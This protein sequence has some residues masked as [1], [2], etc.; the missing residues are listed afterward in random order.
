MAEKDFNPKQ[1]P[2]PKDFGLPYVE[3]KPLSSVRSNSKETDQ[4]PSFES[5]K[6]S[7]F[8]DKDKKRETKTNRPADASPSRA[9]SGKKKVKT[10]VWLV[11]IAIIVAVTVIVIQLNSNQE[12]I[13][14]QENLDVNSLHTTTISNYFE[15]SFK[16]A[17]SNLD[18]LADQ[19]SSVI[20]D[21][22]LTS[23]STNSG[24]S[25]ATNPKVKRVEQKEGNTRYYI[26]IGSFASE[27][28]T[29]RYIQN[30]GDKFSEYY[31]V[32]PFKKNQ[33]YR[34]AIGSYGTLKEASAKLKEMKAQDSTR[35]W[36]LNY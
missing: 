9:K 34:L 35:Y 17:K 27:R 7:L 20:S 33:N 2:D 8:T 25:I 32:Y 5:P 18:S 30:S 1:W 12:P 16:L 26:V 31:L 13:T 15:D 36:I 21:F 10:W 14:E 4:A 3:V 23:N 29:A 22:E 28:E 11:V 6:T 24:T 19:D